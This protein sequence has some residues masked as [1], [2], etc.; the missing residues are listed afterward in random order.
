M[1]RW[2]P[3]PH[4]NVITLLKCPASRGMAS[5]AGGFLE[6]RKGRSLW[7]GGADLGL[8]GRLKALP[9]S[10]YLLRQLGL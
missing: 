2:A 10:A 5:V 4:A 1:L 8:F 6:A 9:G 7:G 3:L